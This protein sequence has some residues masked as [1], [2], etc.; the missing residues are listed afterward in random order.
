V[1]S[2]FSKVLKII[3]TAI[4]KAALWIM[5]GV[6]TVFKTIGSWLQTCGSWF[7]EKIG[8]AWNGLKG[9]TAGIFGLA[10]SVF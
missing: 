5:I 9:L 3:W 10:R 1:A 7:S 2:G 4:K 6:T 8:Q